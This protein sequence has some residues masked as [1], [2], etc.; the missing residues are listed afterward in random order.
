MVAAVIGFGCSS[1]AQSSNLENFAKKFE[2]LNMPIDSILAIPYEN[3]DSLNAQAVNS[4]LLPKRG[5]EFRPFW[6]DKNG[7]LERV[8]Q[9]YGRYSSGVLYYDAVEEEGEKTY[10]FEEKI[11]A[12]GKVNLRQGY[13]SIIVGCI[14]MESIY[15]DLWNLSNEGKPLSV[16]C[17]YYG[18]KER[19]QE[20]TDLYTIVT[21]KINASGQIIW[22]ENNRGLET[23][24]T[25]SLNENGYFQV[26]KEE[27]KGEFNY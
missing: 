17:L 12:I 22:R 4:I 8:M 1:M 10:S 21:S 27:Q 7:K 25:Y 6:V 14:T 5:V 16:V 13:T 20:N 18:S 15:Y 24:R 2:V 23:F 26:E 3:K 11:I 9:Y 19:I